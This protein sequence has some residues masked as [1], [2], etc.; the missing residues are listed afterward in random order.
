[1]QLK[2]KATHPID[3]ILDLVNKIKTQIE[4]E[5]TEKQEEYTLEKDEC[6][7]SQT[8]F[9][10]SIATNQETI[11]DNNKEV[12]L[13]TGQLDSYETDLESAETLRQSKEDQIDSLDAIRE[14]ESQRYETEKTELTE[15]IAA[16]REGKTILQ[17]LL[18]SG[19]STGSFFEKNQ[20]LNKPNTNDFKRVVSLLQTKKNGYM[21]LATL[22]L[23]SV[24]KQ[25][26]DV[27]QDMLNNVL[28]LIESLIN[29]L[30]D[31]LQTKSET[32][33]ARIDTYETEKNNLESSLTLVQSNIASIESTINVI[34]DQLLNLNQD[35]IDLENKIESLET[36]KT[37]KEQECT[38]Y[39]HTYLT[40]S[41]NR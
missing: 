23:E 13:L 35:N 15:L 3:S 26:G 20:I 33:E 11:N 28:D 25:D 40:E 18:V 36:D 1:M 31:N 2:S 21:K 8:D 41:Q 16:L 34:N 24:M 10:V 30:L 38:D 7:S 4:E 12:V 27:D 5:Q 14:E 17:Q 9:E 22:L 37:A 29:Q 19:T 32:E 6:V 39:Y